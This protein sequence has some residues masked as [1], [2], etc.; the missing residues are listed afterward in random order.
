V[1]I[2]VRSIDLSGAIAK[3]GK[4][5]RRVKTMV[6]L[7]AREDTKQYVP[8]QDGALR[9]SAETASVP[10]QG[11]LIYSTVYARAQYYGLPGKRTPG[12]TMQWFEA[13]KAANL[14]KWIKIAE[15]EAQ[16]A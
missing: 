2:R 3:A 9:Q 4:A 11:Q 13:S 15:K 10:E 14:E 1:N 12:T 7:A 16:K 5:E 8:Y 6:T